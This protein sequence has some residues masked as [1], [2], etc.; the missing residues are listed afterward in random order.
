MRNELATGGVAP[1]RQS[2]APL[3]EEVPSGLVR[4]GVLLCI[5]I[6][7]YD[8]VAWSSHLFEPVRNTP[9]VYFANHFVL[10]LGLAIL[11]LDRAAM[12]LCRSS[13]LLPA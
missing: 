6:T 3:A 10:I 13:R 8:I 4:V 11:K 7:E 9:P 5:K 12:L 1:D 2:R